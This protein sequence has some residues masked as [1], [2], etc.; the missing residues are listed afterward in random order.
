MEN[1]FFTAKP[2]V[3]RYLGKRIMC[4]LEWFEDNYEV[5]EKLDIYIT[6]AK[7]IITIDWQKATGSCF[8]PD[9]KM[10]NILIKVSTGDFIERMRRDGYEAA[11]NTEIY[12][13]SREIQHYYQL[14]DDQSLDEEVVNKGADEL[15]NEYLE[16]LAKER[17]YPLERPKRMQIRQTKARRN[18]IPRE[19]LAARLSTIRQ[20]QSK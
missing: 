13:L 15:T 1:I 17:P 19:S 11:V 6:G 2:S 16:Y 8:L 18:A 3:N 9:D 7:Y 5:P 14:I 10:L 20:R 4:F 12:Y